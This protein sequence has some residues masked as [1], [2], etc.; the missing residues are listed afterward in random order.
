MCLSVVNHVQGESIHR[1]CVIESVS[2]H[3]ECVIESVS[4]HRECVIESVSIHRVCVTRIKYRAKNRQNMIPYIIWLRS[5]NE[6][7]WTKHTFL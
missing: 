2:I 1:V 3:R 5:S 6:V 7:T 4:I